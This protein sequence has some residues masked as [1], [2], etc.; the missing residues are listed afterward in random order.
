[1][2]IFRKNKPCNMIVVYFKGEPLALK[3]RTFREAVETV[4]GNITGEAV[5]CNGYVFYQGKELLGVI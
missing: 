5:G 4:V 2:L 1:M 3:F